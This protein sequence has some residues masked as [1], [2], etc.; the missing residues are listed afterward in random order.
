M[1]PDVVAERLEAASTPE[2]AKAASRQIHTLRGVRGVPPGAIARVI[3][4]VWRTERPM[5][6]RDEDSLETL[7]FN[8]WEDGIVAIG[9]LAALVPDAPAEALDIARGWLDRIDDVGTADA[10]GWLVL[11]PCTLAAG[12]DVEEELAPLRSHA[13]PA[14]RRA[15]VMAG[16]A[17]TPEI[18]EGPAA[19]ALRERLGVRDVQFVEDALSE[20]LA[21]ITDAFL[22]DEDPSVRKALRRVLGAWADADPDA[23][24]EYLEGVRGGVPKMLREEVE[25]AARKARRRMAGGTPE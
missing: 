4:E 14:V 8:A 17:M 15:G 18:I 12:A 19:A 21:I 1:N 25:R 6:P 20:N 10:L 24:T 9:L 16:L 22:R 23:A 3:A 2:A 11:G 5:L 7:Y 13:H